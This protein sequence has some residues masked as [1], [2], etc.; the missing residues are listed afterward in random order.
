M[1]RGGSRSSISLFS[2]Q[3]AITSVCG[4]VVLVTLMLAVELTKRVEDATSDSVVDA[5]KVQ[6][7]QEAVAQLQARLQ[8]AQEAEQDD[9]RWRLAGVT[10]KQAQYDL[11]RAQDA[12]D[13]AKDAN[14]QAKKELEE[15]QSQREKNQ[16]KVAARERVQTQLERLQDQTSRLKEQIATVVAT[17]GREVAFVYAA[18]VSEKPWFVETAG[19]KLRV[20][21]P[22]GLAPPCDYSSVKKFMSWAKTRKDRRE[23]FV[24]LARPSGVELAQELESE[25]TQINARFGV[26]L[27]GENVAIRFASNQK[28]ER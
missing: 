14:E 23:F 13:A 7:T 3:D 25:L 10:Y 21:D 9:P 11:Q 8:Q 15:L 5:Q 28:T 1:R 16:D 19:T 6:Q 2:F 4:V 20:H 12:L 18:D 27:L 24:I 17:T 22:E 26:D